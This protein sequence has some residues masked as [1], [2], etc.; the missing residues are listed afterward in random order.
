MVQPMGVLETQN[1]SNN[2]INNKQ[3]Q[4]DVTV[5]LPAI[6]EA[7]IID[8]TV[9]TISRELKTYGC[10]YEIILAED[11]STD[12]TDKKA[13]EL[14]ENFPNIRHIHGEKRLGRGRALKNSFKQSNGNILIYMDVDLAT[15]IKYLNQLI[16]AVTIEDYQL[17]TGSRR[18]SQSKAKRTFTRNIASKV[19]NSMVRFFLR[20]NIKDHQCGFKAF[21]RETVLPLLDEVEANH[22]FWDTE[23]IIRAQRKGYKIKEIPVE[24]RGTR[25]TKVKLFSDS[26]D[27]ARQVLALWRRLNF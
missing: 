10:T 21:Q 6:N 1:T 8:Q 12:G 13:A 19:Y 15:D 2:S 20:S 22:W 26:F 17:A 23:I 16:D 25:E 18:L 7:D 24:W 5:V 27:M 3:M 14:S 9:D 11:G 4:V